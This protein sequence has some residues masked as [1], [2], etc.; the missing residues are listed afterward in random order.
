MGLPPFVYYGGTTHEVT[1]AQTSRRH[2]WGPGQGDS[3][4]LSK[5]ADRIYTGHIKTEGFYPE[6]V[7]EFIERRTV[8]T[9]DSSTE[10]NLL[11]QM[12]QEILNQSTTYRKQIHKQSI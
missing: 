7:R 8:K 4:T 6:Q 10:K 2:P 1:K 3:R 5:Q 11:I 9:A 12:G